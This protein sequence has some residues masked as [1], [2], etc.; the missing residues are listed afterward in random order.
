MKYSILFTVFLLF[1]LHL[2]PANADAG[3]GICKGDPIPAGMVPVAEF[4]AAICP[5]IKGSKNAWELGALVEDVKACLAPD[6]L[7]DPAPNISFVACKPALESKCPAKHDGTANAFVLKH[8]NS[9]LTS[10]YNEKRCSKG[11]LKI[12]SA[13]VFDIYIRCKNLASDAVVEKNLFVTLTDPLPLTGTCDV[14]NSRYAIL[15]PL[16]VKYWPV[17]IALN[18]NIWNDG[19]EFYR[20]SDFLNYN[21]TKPL[22]FV[23]RLYHDNLCEGGPE[24]LNA[25]IRTHITAKSGPNQPERKDIFHCI[26]SDDVYTSYRVDLKFGG[27]EVRP[28]YFKP[29]HTDACGLGGEGAGKINTLHMKLPPGI[30]PWGLAP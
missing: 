15:T 22:D 7:K 4:D 17:C 16:D 2:T 8:A 18:D 27:N 11:E 13:C 19:T 6:Y 24:T 23:S 14:T 5:T 21:M 28:I 10:L 26:P 30:K 9:C 29:I 3:D 25:M 12:G 20:G 1:I